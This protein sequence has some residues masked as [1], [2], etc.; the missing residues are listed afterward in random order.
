MLQATQ[1]VHGALCNSLG[2]V[3]S[4]PLSVRIPPAL[5]LSPPPVSRRSV[6]ASKALRIRPSVGRSSLVSN[7]FQAADVSR[8]YN[9]GNCL[10]NEVTLRELRI[11]KSQEFHANDA[12]L[13]D[14]RGS[15]P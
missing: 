6:L 4:K 12:D 10:P 13:T 15:D 8:G 1:S 3:S 7:L 5:N 9:S 2:E 14:V 11:L